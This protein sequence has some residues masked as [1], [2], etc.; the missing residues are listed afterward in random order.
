[1]KRVYKRKS[2]DDARGLWKRDTLKTL[3]ILEKSFP[4]IGKGE[5][6]H[7]P[8]SILIRKTGKGSME[9]PL[10]CEWTEK[11]VIPH[12]ETVNPSGKFLL[13]VDNHGSRFSTDTNRPLHSKKFG[14]VI[15]SWPPDAYL[16]G[17]RCS[18]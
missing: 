15:M 10:F 2:N 16:A 5:T 17:T 7:L 11:V 13:I 1:M 12:K 3:I 9:L 14:H 6:D 4:L 18:A 8:E